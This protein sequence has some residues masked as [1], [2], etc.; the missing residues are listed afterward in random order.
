MTRNEY[1]HSIGL[2]TELVRTVTLFEG[3]IFDA[4]WHV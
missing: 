3:Q 2:S 1:Q 4:N